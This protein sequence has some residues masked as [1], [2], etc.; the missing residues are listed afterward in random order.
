M[1]QKEIATSYKKG[2]LVSAILFMLALMMG[3]IY[4][5]FMNYITAKPLRLFGWGLIGGGVFILFLKRWDIR[6]NH[7]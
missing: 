4:P 7:H 5:E 6:L 3:V 1:K 2:V